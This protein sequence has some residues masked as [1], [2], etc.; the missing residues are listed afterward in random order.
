MQKRLLFLLGLVIASLAPTKKAAAQDY[1]CGMRCED[2]CYVYEL[3]GKKAVDGTNNP[4]AQHAS[5]FCKAGNTCDACGATRRGAEDDAL[6][7]ALATAPAN[8]IRAVAKANSQRILVSLSRNLVVIRGSDCSPNAFVAVS[9]VSST[10]ARELVQLGVTELEKVAS[11]ATT[12]R[13][14]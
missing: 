2:S 14:N 13:A 1:V 9:A 11:A 4:L 7:V 6:A 3:E 10:R 8:R 5:M 12:K